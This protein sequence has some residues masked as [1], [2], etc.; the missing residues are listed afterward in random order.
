M[1]LSSLQI[2]SGFRPSCEFSF[3]FHQELPARGCCAIVR[4]ICVC[5]TTN[6]LYLTCLVMLFSADIPICRDAGCKTV[7]D[8]IKGKSP[9]EIRKLFDVVNDFTPEE[10]VRLHNRHRYSA[11]RLTRSDLRSTGSNQEGE[12]VGRRSMNDSRSGLLYWVPPDCRA[13][14]H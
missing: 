4:Y 9:E 1:R 10:E 7:A 6:H 11:N 13:G 3:H 12:R 8:M 14:L 5:G 2:T